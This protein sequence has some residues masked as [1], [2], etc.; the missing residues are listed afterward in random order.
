LTL[1]AARL[2]EALGAE[3]RVFD[4]SGL[5]LPDDA[6]ED[7]AKVQEVRGLSAW[8]EAQAWLAGA[9]R[10]HDRNHEG[11]D[12]LD[13]ALDRGG[14]AN[15]GQDARR[16]AGQRRLAILQCGQTAAHSRALDA[17]DHHSQSILAKAHEQLD[18]AG[19]MRPSPYYDA[20]ADVMEELLKFTLLTR[21]VS[22]YLTNRYSERKVDAEKRAARTEGSL[23]VGRS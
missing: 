21:G 19:R 15:P 9:P 13:S 14:A 12:R 11:A 18:E 10:R 3:T 23:L 17:D 8:S 16:D 5:P 2:L 7:H 1:E 6:P 20:L 4:P 22:D